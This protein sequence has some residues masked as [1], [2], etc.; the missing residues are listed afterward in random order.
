MP[1]FT[2][3]HLTKYTYESLVKDSVNHI[4]L[5]PKEDEYQQVLSHDIKISGDRKVDCFFDYYGNQVGFFTYSERHNE[6]EI[7][8]ELR[9][10]T[11]AKELPSES[12]FNEFD[13]KTLDELSGQVP[14][15]D[16]LK[17]E[18]FDDIAEL[19]IKIDEIL[20]E[21]PTPLKAAT[22]FCTFVYEKFQ[23]IQGVTTVQT[24]IE[25]IWQ[26]KAGVCQ[27][28]AHILCQML[29]MAGIP[30]KYVSGYI[31][32]NRNGVRG[33]GATHA[34]VEAYIPGYGWLGF[35]PT[36]NT[37]ANETYVRLALGRSFNDCSPVRGVY[38]GPSSHR[39]TVKVIVSYKD[40]S[41]ETLEHQID[42]AVQ[43]PVEAI[44]AGNSY[45]RNL[46][47]QQQIQQQQ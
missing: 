37:I 17:W 8:S 7:F 16:Y 20:A 38:K 24:Q 29:R 27:D 34:W 47:A 31:C 42:Q 43:K 41:G 13:W 18:P 1:E 9:V 28:F 25:E 36:N 32:P 22:A 10:K 15:I 11:S 2:I 14:Y 23:Y 26:L 46:E 6:L 4:I 5:Y 30:A 3:K 40:G 44:L 45:R 19:K 12:M 21:H 35:D 33:E 39:L